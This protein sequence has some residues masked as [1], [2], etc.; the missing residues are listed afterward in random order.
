MF[1]IDS[2]V[3]ADWAI[4]KIREHCARI[5]EFEK[6]RDSLIS[7]YQS[8]IDAAKEIYLQECEPE[9]N[10]ISNLKSMLLDYAVKHMPDG[11]RT[12]KFPQGDISF[13]SRQPKFY[14]DD[15][16][17]PSAKNE[18]LIELLKNSHSE[19]VTEKVVATVDWAA[20]KKTLKTDDSGEVYDTNGEIVNGLRGE[21]QPDKFV[22]K[23][24]GGEPV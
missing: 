9:L 18:K 14:L 7:E 22:V 15:N 21:V 19:F 4:E 10:A 6:K 13:R 20:F 12:L 24:E 3:K 1:I 11:K 16:S 5:A 17:E 8:R 23:F 2:P